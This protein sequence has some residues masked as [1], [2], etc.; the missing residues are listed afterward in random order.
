MTPV[1]TRLMFTMYYVGPWLL[2]TGFA[3]SILPKDLDSGFTQ[4]LE[5]KTKKQKPEEPGTRSAL[6][7]HQA[8]FFVF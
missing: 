6:L 3:S 5:L 4:D 7:F 1:T 8:F 2:Q